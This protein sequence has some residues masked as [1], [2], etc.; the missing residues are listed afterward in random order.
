VQ[1]SHGVNGQV[2]VPADGHEKSPP[3]TT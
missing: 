2:P 3:L 1:I